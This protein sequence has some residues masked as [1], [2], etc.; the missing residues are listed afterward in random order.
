M[1]LM[2]V[3]QLSMLPQ[4]GKVKMKSTKKYIRNRSLKLPFRLKNKLY[5]TKKIIKSELEENKVD[6]QIA[7]EPDIKKVQDVFDEVKEEETINV[8][9]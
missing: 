9:N 5:R 8:E 3:K 7:K 6:I 4:K 1:T 2:I